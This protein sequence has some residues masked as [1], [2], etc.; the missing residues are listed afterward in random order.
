MVFMPDAVD[1]AFLDACPRLKVVS[2]AL[3]G[4]D[5]FDVAACRRR[6][7]RFA[8]VP[9]LLTVPTA[10]LAVALL[11]GVSRN[12]LEGDRLVRSGCFPG[13]RPVLFGTGLSESIVG[14]VGMGAVG[15][16][17]AERLSGF[18][19]RLLYSDPA[20]PEPDRE[21]A[22]GLKRTSF[23]E[24][25]R[26]SD[27]VV[28]AAP[29]RRDTLHLINGETIAWMKPNAYLVNISRGSVVDE[30]A[31]A[32]ALRGGKLAGYAA[33]VFAFEDWAR[34]DRPREIPKV[35]LD[36]TGRTLF[37]PHLGSA[38]GPVRREV[39]MEAARNILQAFNG[40]SLEK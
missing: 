34:P 17:I 16:A 19:P 25:L 3:K 36:E 23:P 28:L 5:N 4:Y 13:W 39:A 24:L 9:D 6:G 7:I 22:L 26:R 27:F 14:I 30:E 40:H 20:P 21:A 29:L 10:E 15:Q 12:V 31:V 2:A 35:L 38:V 37:T 8:I 33:D 1:D 18:R 32:G 11:L